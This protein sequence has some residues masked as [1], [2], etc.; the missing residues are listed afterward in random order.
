MTDAFPLTWPA[1]V[2]RTPAPMR[3]RA[4][5][6]VTLGR[7]LDNIEEEVRKFGGSELIIS[8][9]MRPRIDG[10]PYADQVGR[11]F[12]DPGV[13]AWF[14]RKKKAAVIACDKYL[15][16]EHNVHAIGLTLEALRGIERWGS[17]DLADQAFSGFLALPAPGEKR[18]RPWREVMG[19]EPNDTPTEHDIE[20]FY[21]DGAIASHPDKGGTDEQMAELNRAREEALREIGVAP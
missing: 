12:E 10:R 11:I 8:C 5:F 4:I 7:S 6:K 15:M 19:F 3:K 2:A 13:S 16:I 17:S 9:N 18:K 14:I 21:R 1:S 20:R